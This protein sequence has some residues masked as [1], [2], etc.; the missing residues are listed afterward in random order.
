MNKS[1]LAEFTV[2]PGN[3]E[4]VAELVQDYAARVREEPGSLAFEVYTKKS[5]PL[6]YWI[7]EVYASEPPS[8]PTCRPPTARRSTRRSSP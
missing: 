8:R 2:R 4:P 7:F 5:N 3:E 6:A 1:L